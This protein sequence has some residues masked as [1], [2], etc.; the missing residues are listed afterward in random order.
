MTSF[1]VLAALS[2]I[3]QIVKLTENRKKHDREQL[4]T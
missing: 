3:R 2:N 1:H 4:I